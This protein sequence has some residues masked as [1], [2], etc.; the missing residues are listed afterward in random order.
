MNILKLSFDLDSP[1]ISCA[2]FPE[3]P[4]RR[5]HRCKDYRRA[6]MIPLILNQNQRENEKHE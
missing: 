5:K 2:A 1:C 3:C 6:A 4:K